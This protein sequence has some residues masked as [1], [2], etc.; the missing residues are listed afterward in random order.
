MTPRKVNPGEEHSGGLW[1]GDQGG[2]GRQEHIESED[3]KG[4]VSKSR[5]IFLKTAK[6]L[7]ESR[8]ERNK[9]QV[10]GRVSGDPKSS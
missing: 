7:K 5:K 3:G 1:Q 2:R 10:S 8:S 9:S 6:G 4:K